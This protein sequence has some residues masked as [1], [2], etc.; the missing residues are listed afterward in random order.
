MNIT[1]RVNRV[2]IHSVEV[3]VTY[4]G[5][6]AMA[7]LPELQVELHDEDNIQGSIT[8]HLRAKADIDAAN[9]IFEAGGYA[10]VSFDKGAAPPTAIS[11]E[12]EAAS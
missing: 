10:T 6:Q 8:L 3:P 7:M 2:S 1:L 12:A 11:T 4:N 9:A 5:E